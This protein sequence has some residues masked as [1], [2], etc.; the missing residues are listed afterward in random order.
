M[1]NVDAFGDFATINA[2]SAFTC[3][4]AMGG[5]ATYLLAVVPK[6]GIDRPMVRNI[7][8][9]LGVTCV[10]F[11]VAQSLFM[12]L[13][14]PDRTVW[15]TIVLAGVLL[16]GMAFATTFN[17]AQRAAGNIIRSRFSIAVIPPLVTSTGI[18]LT[19]SAGH[20]IGTI[21]LLLWNAVGWLALWLW[22]SLWLM[23]SY[24]AD[25]GT[26]LNISRRDLM[27]TKVSQAG[28]S[29][30]DVFVVG[31][32]LGA[33]EGPFTPSPAE[34]PSQPASGIRPSSWHT[35]HISASLPE[36]QTRWSP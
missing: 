34:S 10:A 31:W 30:A 1:S 4:L 32:L 26:P 12:G 11:V 35:A 15:S 3:V 33:R 22:A 27:I 14:I 2:I 17:E 18:V 8:L 36:I 20:T 7:N 29:T 9:R 5:W 25:A 28:L 23:R 6:Q 19:H 24:S 21:D 16:T 13:S